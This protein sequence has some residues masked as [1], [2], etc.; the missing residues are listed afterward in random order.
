[1][2]A[3]H[4]GA[5]GEPK[6]LRRFL[7]YASGE[8][9]HGAEERSDVLVNLPT[10]GRQRERPPVKQPVPDRLLEPRELRA[11]RRL[12][13]AVRNQA[14]PGS[15]AAG[16]RD[17]IEE[18]E[19][20]NVQHAARLAAAIE[21]IN[22]RRGIINSPSAREP[23]QGRAMNS[24]DRLTFDLIRRDQTRVRQLVDE[25][26]RR[27]DLLGLRFEGPHVP[28]PLPDVSP[29][30]VVP[31][32]SWQEEPPLPTPPVQEEKPAANP[33]SPE[34]TPA[35]VSPQP[36]Q[37]TSP[38]PALVPDEPLELRVG[39]YW[40]ARIGIV[41]LLTGLVFLGNYAY[42]RIVPLLGATGKLSLLALAGVALGGVGAW[43]ERSRESMRNYGRV[44]LAG[45]AATLYY[46]AYAA[47][48]VDA[49]R[50]IQSPVLGGGLLLTMAG[51]FI[52]WA[53]RK[54]S[55]A[56]AVPAVLLAYYTSAINAIGGFTLFSNLLL[57]TAAVFFLVRRRWTRL[58]Y[59]SVA[60]TYGSYAFWR[61]YEIAQVGGTGSEF[62]MGVTFLAGYWMLFTVA[63]FLAAPK[64]MGGSE[65]VAFLTANNGA[66]F[67]FAAQHFAT[68]RPDAFWMFALGYGVVLLGLGALAW[69]V[70][71]E[72]RALDGAY[73]A[74]GIALVTLGL[75][76]KMT[77]PQLA[78]VLAVESATLLTGSRRR[79]GW[80]F[81]VAAGLCAVGACGL[82]LFELSQHHVAPLALGG[83]VAA[84][85]LFNAWWSKRLRG[86]MERFSE[87][88]FGFAALGL[89]VAGAVI[90]QTA[91]APWQAAAF[92]LAA[93]VSVAALR[94]R[95][96]EVAFPGQIFLL[97]GAG[98]FLA[99]FT[100]TAPEPWWN[101]LPLVIA[102]I[103]LM[104]WWQR[105]RAAELTDE[106]RAFPHLLCA[107]VA[108]VTGSVWM[109]DFVRGDAWLIA[110]S[111][112]ALGTL[113]YGL[114]T[115]A[116][117]LAL[118][119]QAFTVMATSSFASALIMGH[120]GWAAAL[121]PIVN[122]GLT[123]LV[124]A[125]FG[126]ARTAA[127]PEFV[128]PEKI[129]QGYRLIALAMLGGWAFEYV[130]A[131]WRVA[132]FAGFGCALLLAGAV[133]GN[134]ERSASGAVYGAV[135]LLLFWVHP[136]YTAGWADLLAIFAIP[137]TLRL[138][139][140][141]TGESIVSLEVRNTLV[142][143]AMAS[144]W[145]W[146]TRWTLAHGNADQL[147]TAWAVLAL[148]IFAAGLGVRE[149]LYRLGG[150]A[151]LGLAV[152][153]LFI[154]D[155]WRFDSLLRIVSFLVLGLVLLALSFV[156]NR[157]A[158]AIRRWI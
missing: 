76:A 152:G 112:A 40:M 36:G 97:L 106:I 154:V 156:Y 135:A 125:R 54:R 26:D 148:I 80:L 157:F 91:G 130:T 94:V 11:D 69:R 121:A 85:L 12:L 79:H 145:L 131:P 71:S 37:P 98:V 93:C 68:H 78:V 28:P 10:R 142:L 21:E 14:Q 73:L 90:W 146:V 6:M 31:A 139:R 155:V 65:R 33:A 42:H 122:A 115:R 49:L 43:L 66:F 77:G 59:V 86:E 61:F 34:P 15:D 13:D 19:M 29:A 16:L 126:G 101:P 1:M 18:L 4:A 111:G 129:A 3:E 136:N 48:Y 39:T 60:A 140:R 92:A 24:A 134:R 51:G 84:L 32:R 138:G 143:V 53:D 55:E 102:A 74:Q 117:A 75:A 58:T 105:Q 38:P 20:V 30:P 151:V 103:G 118:V 83:P 158:A 113:I 82:A 100:G 108:V 56:L 137:A 64:V 133:T 153:R 123:S 47:H 41:I 72:E 70:R 81:E 46:T 5:R 144:L 67:A 149:R 114:L 99:R 2:L 8:F 63:A 62:G 17:V 87:F 119:G 89:G 104:H 95:L 45:G 116:S 27:I 23:W 9:A 128:R 107:A 110:T 147:T 88:A 44:L 52:W 35:A 127:L 22:G 124:V 25:L 7:A 96:P 50:V 141:I 57:T 109:R 120:P 150:F 132:W